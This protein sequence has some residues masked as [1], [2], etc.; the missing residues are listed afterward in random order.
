LHRF[1]ELKVS[2]HQRQFGNLPFKIKWHSLS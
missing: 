2:L 1:S